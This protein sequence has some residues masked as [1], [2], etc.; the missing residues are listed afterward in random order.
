MRNQ[1]TRAVFDYWINLKGDR[2]A[3]LRTEIDPTALRHLLPHLFIA[4][5]DERGVLAF[6][7]AGTRICDLFGYELRSMAFDQVWFEA[8]QPL[9]IAQNVIRHE[10]PALVDLVAV[11]ADARQAYEMLL[12]P[13]RSTDGME[14]D[15]LFGSLLPRGAPFPAIALPVDGLEMESWTFLTGGASH[16]G[17]PVTVDHQ[18]PLTGLRQP[19]SD[20]PI[21]DRKF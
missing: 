7:L 18:G 1:A 13:L 12:L 14:S 17:V 20:L 9:H 2:A 11:T 10:Q 21:R 4:A 19:A 3:P 15:R 6:R 5:M 8:E 16:F